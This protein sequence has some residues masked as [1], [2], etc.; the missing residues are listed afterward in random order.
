MKKIVSILG[1]GW[2]GKALKEQLEPQYYVYCLGRDI[3]ENF[4][5]GYYECD[6]F[7]I[8]IPPRENYLQLLTETLQKVGQKCQ[9]IFLSSTSFYDGK[10]LVVEGEKLVQ[11]LH[12]KVLILR[13]S[14]LM[15]YDRVAGKYAIGKTLAHD[16][17]VNYV[18]RDDVVKIIEL[19]ITEN[20][21]QEIFDVTAPKHPKQS[22]V[23]K[24]NA[25]RFG[26]E[27]TYFASNEVRG[28]LVSSEKLLE[29]FKYEFLYPNPLEF[30]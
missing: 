20:V 10:A 26:W 30:W 13:L 22:E 12:Q 5:N 7:I 9:V 27:A 6:T 8:A 11:E 1:C 14:G 16:K 28:K 21:K 18:H 4:K 23:Y 2:V 29:H 19:C 17:Y 24:K 3:D 25:E 15:G